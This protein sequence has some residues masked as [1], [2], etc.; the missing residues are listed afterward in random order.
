M[1][2]DGQASLFETYSILK[3]PLGRYKI[4]NWSAEDG[5]EITEMNLWVRRRDLQGALVWRHHG[6]MFCSTI[7]HIFKIL[8][9]YTGMSGTQCDPD[10]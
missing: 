9:S 4:G 1:S 3:G 8:T 7:V 5:L 2:N 10:Q 6:N